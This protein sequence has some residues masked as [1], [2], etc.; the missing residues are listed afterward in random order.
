[1]K[2]LRHDGK[3]FD[4]QTIYGTANAYFGCTFRR[5]VIVFKGFPSAFVNCQFA[6]CVWHLDFVLHDP[7]QVTALATFIDQ[8]VKNS[9]PGSRAAAPASAEQR[10]A[11]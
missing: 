10:P 8:A 2:L 3:T 7:E 5:C 1:M 11:S 4:N 9:L 6:D